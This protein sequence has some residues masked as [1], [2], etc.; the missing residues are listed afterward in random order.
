[1]IEIFMDMLL[2]H[3]DEDLE[4]ES[5]RRKIACALSQE[6]QNKHIVMYTDLETRCSDKEENLD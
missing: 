3:K 4:L 2:K 1:M 6:L 5:S